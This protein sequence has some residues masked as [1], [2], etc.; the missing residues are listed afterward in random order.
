MEALPEFV[1]WSLSVRKPV[2][3]PDPA[4][5][6]RIEQRMT[7]RI[8]PR[9]QPPQRNMLY[10]LPDAAIGPH[11]IERRIGDCVK[12]NQISGVQ[13]DLGN[14][15]LLFMS[16]DRIISATLER[17]CRARDFYS[18]FYLSKSDDG[19]LCVARDTLQS[20]SGANCKLTRLRE[21]VEVGD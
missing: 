7:I 3:E 17:T 10:E 1:G 21:L 2:F 13:T 8:T 9:S 16:D 6:V 15:L 18:G 5:Q 14:R 12:A 11:F 20:R 4:R 19:K